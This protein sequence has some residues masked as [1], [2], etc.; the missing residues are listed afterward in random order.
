[1]VKDPTIGAV[2]WTIVPTSESEAYGDDRPRKPWCGVLRDTGR[3]IFRLN[4]CNEDLSPLF[5]GKI[6]HD[7]SNSSA[8]VQPGRELHAT[9]QEA[10][11]AYVGACEMYLVELR[12]KIEETELEIGRAKLLLID[13]IT[14]INHAS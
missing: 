7:D 3:G 12:E 4:Y 6:E 13:T 8:Y 10:L 5:D 11:R 9:R 14:S 2:Y 1:M